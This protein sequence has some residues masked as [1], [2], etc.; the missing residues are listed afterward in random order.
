MNELIKKKISYKMRG[1]KLTATHRK[2]IS[3]TMKKIKKSDEHKKA[4][5]E[6]MKIIWLNRKKEN[7]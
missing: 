3:Q 2:H 7:E 6:S 1:R 4:I 5:S